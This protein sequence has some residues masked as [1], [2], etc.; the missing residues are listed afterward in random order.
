MKDKLWAFLISSV[1]EGQI[2][3]W[4]ALALRWILYPLDSFYWKMSA[5][6]GY[7][8]ERNVWLIDGVP[9]CAKS[10]HDLANATGEAFT[11]ENVNGTIIIRRGII[12]SWRRKWGET[13]GLR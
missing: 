5:T 1:P 13:Y 4:W 8:M 12:V 9:F 11:A 3:P 2:M 6:R 7:Q 10:L